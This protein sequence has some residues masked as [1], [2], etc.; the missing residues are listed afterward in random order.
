MKN[1]KFEMLKIVL[2]LTFDC[3]KTCF[4]VSAEKIITFAMQNV[5]TSYINDA[6][7]RKK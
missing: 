1:Y 3:K 5:D 6:N 7:N 2:I 4:F